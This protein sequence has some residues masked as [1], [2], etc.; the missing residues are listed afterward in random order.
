LPAIYSL[1]TKK[2]LKNFAVIG[3]SR[4]EN[5]MSSII[6]ESKKFVKGSNQK[7]WNKI[8]KRS[9]YIKLNF[10]DSEGYKVFGKGC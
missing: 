9:E 7:V 3:V 4:S 5:S 1:V 8:G 10:E 6:G 2:K